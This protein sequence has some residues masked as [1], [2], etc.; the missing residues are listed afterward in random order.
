MKIIQYRFIIVVRI[1]IIDMF[2]YIYKR[3]TTCISKIYDKSEK[4][5]HIEPVHHLNFIL[6]ANATS[7]GFKK[8]KNYV[9]GFEI[10]HY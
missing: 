1:S 2:E 9:N 6:E 10:L 4:L 5:N 8:Y 3:L 7:K